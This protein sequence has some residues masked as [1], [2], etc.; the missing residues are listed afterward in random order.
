MTLEA[1]AK[2]ARVSTATVSRVLN[3]LGVVKDSTRR[4]VMQ[5]VEELNY[6]PNL[7]ARSLAGG[8]TR[9][10]GM[11]VSNISNPFF[12]DIF[13][14]MEAAAKESDYEVL[15]EHTDYRVAQL[16]SSVRSMIGRRVAGLALM[17]SEMDKS[18]MAEVVASNLPVVFYDVGEAARNLTNIRVRYEVGMH[19]IVHYLYSLGHRRMAFLGHHASLGP[20]ETRK[21]AFAEA[22]R[23]YGP[24]VEFTT[25]LDNDTPGGGMQAAH[26]LLGSGFNPTA[27]VCVNDYMAIGALRAVRSRG[28]SVPDDISVTG[29]DNIEFSE[30]TNPALTTVNIPRKAIGHMAVEALLKT[31]D[32]PGR[33]I[34]IEPELVLRDST[35][36]Y[37]ERN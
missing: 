3:N 14:G 9:T 4:R 25:A 32:K 33:E 10:L 37:R 31:D 18:I 34:V 29:F 16:A 36:S 20:L 17:V 19:R 11:I 30:F 22:V 35:G 27:V 24:G 13:L 26:E 28:L 12:A 1:V 7:H 6:H 5:A 23:Q 8:R 2:R 15:V 21:N